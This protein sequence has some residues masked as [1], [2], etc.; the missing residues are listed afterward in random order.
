MEHG[1]TLL[2]GLAGVA[3]Q[4]VELD[5]AGARVVHVRTTDET[6][7]ACRSCG[8]FSTAVSGNVTTRPKD[9]PY[10]QA[11]TCKGKVAARR[12]IVDAFTGPLRHRGG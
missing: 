7:S 12:I 10:G 4:Q 2:L 1:T 3:V 5:D 11:P 8:A 6:A 9:L